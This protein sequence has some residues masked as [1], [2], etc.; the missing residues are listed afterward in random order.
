[1]FT[2]ETV[3]VRN[4]TIK[5]GDLVVTP[6]GQGI[7]KAI[8]PSVYLNLTENPEMSEDAVVVNSDT[9]VVV[10]DLFSTDDADP[11]D[12][13]R[14]LNFIYNA[15][16]IQLLDDGDGGFSRC[17]ASLISKHAEINSLYEKLRK[18]HRKV[19]NFY[20]DPMSYGAPTEDFQEDFDRQERKLLAQLAKEAKRLRD[21]E[22]LE[23]V[24]DA[25][26]K[27]AP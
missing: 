7:V 17:P 21:N 18:H 20:N 4:Q 23:F 6:D 5:C 3:E 22:A 12:S 27:W 8:L 13:L 25:S 26:E 19:S 2:I 10:V 11:P 16:A 15:K 14:G 9:P 1:M 24:V